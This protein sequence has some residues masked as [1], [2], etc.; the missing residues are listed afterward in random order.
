MG[1]D[2]RYQAQGVLRCPW[3]VT[4]VC[5]PF[6]QNPCQARRQSQSPTTMLNSHG[7]PITGFDSARSGSGGGIR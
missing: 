2:R 3:A 5:P 7:R 6:S 1:I 4:T